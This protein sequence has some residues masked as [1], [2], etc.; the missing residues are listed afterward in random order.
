MGLLRRLWLLVFPERASTQTWMILTFALFV[1]L[2]VVAVGLYMA[3]V[4]RAETREAMRQTLRAQAERIAVQV[5]GAGS[6]AQRAALVRDIAR[7]TDLRVTVA[8]GDRVRWDV[9]GA[10]SLDD[11]R[12]LEQPEM[13]VGV[14][15]PVRFSDRV[16]ATGQR[17][18]Y[19][20]LHRPSSDLVV[21][22][23][24]PEPPLF[25][26]VERMQIALLVGMA[27]ALLLS[28]L[29]SW[30]AAYQVT[31]PLQTIRNSAKAIAQDRFDGKIRV[32]SRAAEFQD[33]GESLNRMSDAFRKKIVDLERLT[34]LQSEF[35]GNVS[36]EVRNPIH[37]ISGYLEALSMP[38]LRDEQRKRYA[39]KALANLHRLSA[40][41]NDLIEIARLEYRE[42]LVRPEPFELQELL[43][44]VAEMLRPKAEREGLHLEADN[45]PLLVEA[46]R[47]RIR[48]VLINLVDNAIAYTDEGTVRV[49]FRRRLGK[50]RIEVVDTGRGIEEG[51][52]E[53]IFERF[54]RVNPDRSRKSGGTGLGLSIVKQILQAHG[55]AVH[56]EST[57]GRGTRFWFELPYAGRPEEADRE[58]QAAPEPLPEP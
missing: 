41:F 7:L 17:M 57:Y 46:D 8:S 36:H 5:E 34:R 23:G 1:G 4:L 15:R 42:D 50:V 3:F 14:G 45:A 24:Q 31:T 22:V 12:V 33:L 20:A 26:M 6:E 27:M 37:A 47:N 18:L 32:D 53:R 39:E 21:R 52:L 11:S 10:R 25:A 49:R 48:Q 40:L 55:E 13:D 54:Y 9:Q 44:E 35:I 38:N 30:V 2:A 43:D 19:V 56:V 16:E 28:I 51:H 29:G 58:V